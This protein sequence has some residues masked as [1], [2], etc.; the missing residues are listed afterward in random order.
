MFRPGDVI[1]S[2][3]T[4]RVLRVLRWPVCEV[5]SG[6]PHRRGRITNLAHSEVIL[7][8]R[9]YQEKAK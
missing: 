4:D 6:L 2:K 8:G 3:R 1:R 5:L 7:V 9:N